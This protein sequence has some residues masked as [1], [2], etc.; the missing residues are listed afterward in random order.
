M[1]PSAIRSDRSIAYLPPPQTIQ[2]H[3]YVY[4]VNVDNHKILIMR[5]GKSCW[6]SNCF[7]AIKDGFKLGWSHDCPIDH[8]THQTFNHQDLFSKNDQFVKSWKL[9]RDKWHPYF[10]EPMK[11][12]MAR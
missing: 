1:R 9:F 4:D 12:E 11:M 2:Y 10:P 3:D 6:S 8:L 7:R 5:N